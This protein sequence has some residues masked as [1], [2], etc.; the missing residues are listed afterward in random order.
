MTGV[1]TDPEGQWS[2]L[3]LGIWPGRYNVRVKS[4][5]TV[6][7]VRPVVELD[8]GQHALDM[9]ELMEGDANND[10]RIDAIDASLLAA[11]FGTAQDEAG[12]DWRADFD[13]DGRV[14][15]A[16]QALLQAHMGVSGDRVV[17]DEDGGPFTLD[18]A[19]AGE[20]GDDTVVEVPVAR[21]SAAQASGGVALSLVP[22]ES[23]VSV[24]DI[25]TLEVRIEAGSQAVD[26]AAVHLDFDP[27]AL[28]VVGPV[29]R[30]AASIEAGSAL[31]TVFV[32]RADNDR[33]WIDF[34]A[35]AVG[36]EAPSG[37]FTVAT[38][39]L[40]T[41]TPGTSTVRF[42]F[43]Q[44]RM[45]NVLLAGETVLGPASAARVLAQEGRAVYLPSCMR[46]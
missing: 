31:G 34:T 41:L 37:T 18:G 17:R 13:Q 16:D 23:S 46:H 8:G 11:A 25:V 10:D 12:F 35:G 21:A 2:A 38:L 9:G 44:Q 40:R 33:G 26:T 5:H 3:P 42:T 19:I 43:D 36:Q 14:G 24:G 22:E 45:T 39:R 30:P 29:G 20:P 6:T 32:N 28:E 7:N 4:L 27:A 1:M 15:E